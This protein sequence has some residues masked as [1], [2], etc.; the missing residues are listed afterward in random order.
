MGSYKLI[1]LAFKSITRNKM[2]S[3]L[4]MLGIIIGVASVI[5]LVSIGNGAKADVEK[6]VA[7]LGTN[8]III[9]TSRS[10]TGGV[11]G[12][13]ESLDTL[14]L[15]DYKLLKEKAT[16]ISGISPVIK[17]QCQVIASATNWNT[18]I[19]GVSP[20][21]LSVCNFSVESGEFFTQRDVKAMSKVAVVGKTVV[22]ELFAD[23]NPIG[24]KIRI[25]NVP[26]RIIGVLAEK[27]QSGMGTDQDDVIL[28]PSTT[29]LYRLGNGKTVRTIMASAVTPEKMTDARTQITT[30]LRASHRLSA[31]QENDF[32]IRDQ[33]EINNMATGVT[34]TLT[35]LLSAIA[36]VS[37]LVGGIGVMNIMLVSVTER[38]REI[39]IRMAV[40]ARG[41]DILLQF[42]VEAVILSLIGGIVGVVTGL[43]LAFLMGNILGTSVVMTGSVIIY[44]TL[45]TGAVGVFFGF[46]P[47]RKAANLNPI[48]ALKYE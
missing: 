30:I 46:Y 20:D 32:R 23:Q 21:Y 29:V 3:L 14:D 28:A 25:R 5:S 9:H 18:S 1:N 34:G 11:R 13:S 44:T 22:D 27:G 10:K 40:G 19:Y 42:L 16:A 31:G 6:Q 7:S 47:A 41:I 48:D 33:T 2:R 26:F 4:T 8:L 43:G 35:V 15:N 12:G 36:G 39:G 37:L 17:E 38:T 24:K 45:F